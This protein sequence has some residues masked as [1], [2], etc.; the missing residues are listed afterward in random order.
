MNHVHAADES[1]EVAVAACRERLDA[2]AKP[3]GSLGKL[4]RLACQLAAAQRTERPRTQPRAAILFAGD[5]GVV[6]EGV[7]M[8]PADVTRSVA[9]TIAAGGGASSVLARRAATPLEVV[10]VGLIGTP[11][12]PP[13]RHERIAEGTANLRHHAA[14]TPTQYDAAVAVGQR[15]ATESI[16]AGSRLLVTGEMG[17]GNTTPAAAM[18]ALLTGEPVET[19]VGP[20]AGADEATLARKRVVVGDA[21]R[22]VGSNASPCEIGRQ[23]GGLE[24]AAMTGLFLAAAERDVPV[25]LDGFIATAAALV[26]AAEVTAVSTVLLAAHRSSE[27]GHT[28]ALAKLG[29]NPILEGWNLRLG[30]GSGALLALPLLDAAAA[31]VDEMAT[32]EEV[33][34]QAVS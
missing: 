24:I 10:D 27:P 26:A 4:E 32:L 25:V 28:A 23:V 15:L 30:E 8:W 16:D 18:T 5:H 2:L 21:V 1:S 17:I 34:T 3:P 22:R 6:S 13:V 20:G 29:L 19:V 12:P 9:A 31:I 11:L 33:L 7:T 14:M